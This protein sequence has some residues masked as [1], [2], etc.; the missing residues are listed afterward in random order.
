MMLK[1]VDILAHSLL[2]VPTNAKQ[3]PPSWDRLGGDEEGRREDQGGEQ[4]DA[5]K[6]TQMWPTYVETHVFNKDTEN[7]Q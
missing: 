2:A 5:D 6:Q 7:E 4:K 1:L 3:V